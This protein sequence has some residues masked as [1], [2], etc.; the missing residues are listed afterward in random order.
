MSCYDV[1]VEL[2]AA[3]FA[4]LIVLVALGMPIAADLAEIG[5]PWLG[6]QSRA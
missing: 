6:G 5:H 4:L 2:G 1:H 3:G